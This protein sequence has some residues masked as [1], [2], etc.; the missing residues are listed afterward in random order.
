[1]RCFVAG[2]HRTG[3]QIWADWGCGAADHETIFIN[4]F[5]SLRSVVVCG[6]GAVF[7]G[8][9]GEMFGSVMKSSPGVERNGS[10][11]VLSRS[12]FCA[13]DMR[14]D[15]HLQGSCVCGGTQESSHCALG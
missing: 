8:K 9:Q 11:M 1:M 10:R 6:I 7:L 5:V 14:R 15:G 2:T 13:Y 12:G 3:V 4:G